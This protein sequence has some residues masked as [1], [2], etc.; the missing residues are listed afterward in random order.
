ML[1]RVRW[2]T[3]AHSSPSEAIAHLYEDA[4]INLDNPLTHSDGRGGY[5]VACTAAALG[6]LREAV[7]VLDLS[8]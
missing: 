8:D 7:T 3:I 1:L 4:P 6:A 5:D 2:S